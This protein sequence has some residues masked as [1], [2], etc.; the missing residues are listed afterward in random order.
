MAYISVD[1]DIDEFDDDELIDELESRGYKVFDEDEVNPEPI[2]AL[3]TA[4]TTMS[5]EFF[6][7]ELKKYFRDHLNVSEY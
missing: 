4:Y 3:Y 5:P 6:Q 7:K 1:V 2:K